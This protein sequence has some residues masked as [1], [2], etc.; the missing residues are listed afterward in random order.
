MN[1]DLY[2]ED[3][4]FVEL[5]NSGDRKRQCEYRNAV[6]K[7]IV[8]LEKADKDNR[9]SEEIWSK[10]YEQDVTVR[11]LTKVHR[12]FKIFNVVMLIDVL[13]FICLR[14]YLFYGY[15]HGTLSAT[16]VELFAV[17]CG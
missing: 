16:E 6:I 11:A 10:I 2:K 3:R 15:S 1:D 7:A 14:A 4:F 12:L 9:I 13:A 5:L 8:R 17:Y